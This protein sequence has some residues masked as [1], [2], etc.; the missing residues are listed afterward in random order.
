M[1]ILTTVLS[2]RSSSFILSENKSINPILSGN[3]KREL[4][5]KAFAYA[6]DHKFSKLIVLD[7]MGKVIIEKRFT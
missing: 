1:S 4:M 5:A 7:E 2:R 6:R 3:T